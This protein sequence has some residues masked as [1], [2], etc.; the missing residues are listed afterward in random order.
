MA[1]VPR[2]ADVVVVGGGVHGAS[3]AYHLARRK[4]GRVVL[5]ERKFLASGPTGRSSALV[6]RFYAWDFL[7]RTASASA[8]T[9]QR[10]ADVIGG[11]DEPGFRPGR[12]PAPSARHRG[13]GDAA[14][15]PDVLL[16][17]PAGVRVAPRDPRPAPRGLHAPGDRE[18]HHPRPVH[19]RRRGGSRLVQ[20]RGGSGRDP[21]Q[22]G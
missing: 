7:T 18:P 8:D 5:V 17:A 22:R 1:E 15:P 11:A 12:P 21:A 3:V 16:P 14:A 9:F 2:T 20:R 4:A 13:A 10:W 6:R 19:V